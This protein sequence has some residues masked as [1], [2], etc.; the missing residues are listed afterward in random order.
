MAT[1]SNKALPLAELCRRRNLPLRP[2]RGALRRLA[3]AKQLPRPTRTWLMLPDAFAAALKK[4]DA[5]KPA[6][7][8]ARSKP[9]KKKSP[10]PKPATKAPAK[11][12]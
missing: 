7:A 12:V 11:K 5:A 4:I 3:Q 1:Q 8:A 2:T 9:T 6:K 10:K